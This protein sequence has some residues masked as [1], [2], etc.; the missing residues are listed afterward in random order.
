MPKF[1]KAET[2]LRTDLDRW[3]YLLKNMN[4]MEKIPL[5][6]DK[7]VFQKVFQIAEVSNLT[8]EERMLYERSL[9]EKWDYENVLA[10]A[11]NEA[12]EKKYAEGIEKGIEKGIHEEKLVT[13]RKLKAKGYSAE[14]IS[15]ITELPTSEIERLKL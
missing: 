11:V 3:F 13:A 1:T 9:K 12:G 15:E 14:E 7:R 10:Y 8:K 2:E 6:F 5:Y 4:R